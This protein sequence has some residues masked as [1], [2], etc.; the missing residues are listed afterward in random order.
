MNLF[1]FSVVIS[2]YIH[3]QT[4]FLWLNFIRRSFSFRLLKNVV[5]KSV[6]FLLLNTYT[7]TMFVHGN[8]SLNTKHRRYFY[9]QCC[10][11]SLQY[12][13][14][15]NVCGVAACTCIKRRTHTPNH[16]TLPQTMH[17]LAFWVRARIYSLQLSFSLTLFVCVYVS[18]CRFNLLPINTIL[19]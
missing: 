11:W 9:D 10:V 8:N 1:F 4:I 12:D 17:T 19:V 13:I 2:S 7:D 16:K 18:I 5:F 6:F 15:G 3:T 14:D